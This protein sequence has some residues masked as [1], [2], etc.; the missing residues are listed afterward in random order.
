MRGRSNKYDEEREK[1]KNDT[2]SSTFII[3][4]SNYIYNSE[5]DSK[6][7]KNSSSS[8]H[9]PRLITSYSQKSSM[10]YQEQ[11]ELGNFNIISMKTGRF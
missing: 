3:E 8:K 2:D 10:Y 6:L 4:G 5:T 7:W 11:K 1:R 9:D